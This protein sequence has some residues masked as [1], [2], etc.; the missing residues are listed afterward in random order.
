MRGRFESIEGD[1]YTVIIDYAHSADA[2][3]NILLTVKEFAKGKIITVFGC[4][5]DRD[6]L[7]RPEM[8]KVAR[9]HSDQCIITSDNPRSEDPLKIISNIE[10]GV[11][12]TNCNYIKIVD[13]KKAIHSA[14]DQ[15]SNEDVVIIAGKGHEDYQ[16]INGKKFYFDDREVVLSY[17]NDTSTK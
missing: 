2:L 3:E 8:G 12:F 4:G 14:L 6:P 9:T 17:L 16:E 1:G 7:K 13:R 10:K 11:Q 15:A 5:G